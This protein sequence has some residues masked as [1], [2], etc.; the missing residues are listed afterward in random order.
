VD[1][2]PGSNGLA[3]A[4]ALLTDVT[5][6]EVRLHN[7]AL[8]AAIRTAA[9]LVP[10][11]HLHDEM[12]DEPRTLAVQLGHLGELS[13]FAAAQLDTWLRGR[14]VVLGRVPHA[15]AD[16]ADALERATVQRLAPLRAELD[17]AA[18]ALARVLD[19]MV[20][21]HL[22]ATVTDVVIG[23]EP[24]TGYLHRYVLGHKAAHLAQLRRTL[25]GAGI[26]SGGSAPSDARL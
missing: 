20:D 13:R 26:T 11:R 1:G 2:I 19:R 25:A 16:L 7:Q 17:D 23:R 10:E 18:A 9:G 8:D 14:R 22:A 4:G 6:T 21:E 5:A 3:P 24:L 15:D 12:S